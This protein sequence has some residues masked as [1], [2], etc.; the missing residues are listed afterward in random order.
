MNIAYVIFSIKKYKGIEKMKSVNIYLRLVAGLVFALSAPISNAMVIYDNGVQANEV[1]AGVLSTTTAN[2]DA[3]VADDF[4]LPT[5]KW[6]ITDLHWLGID[7]ENDPTS[8][9]DIYFYEDSSGQPTGGP[10]DPSG[11]AVEFRSVSVTGSDTGETLTLEN[12]T[13]FEYS[14]FIDPV[15]LLGDKTYWL[16]IQSTGD[17]SGWFFALKNDGG[18]AKFGGLGN[19]YW[20]DIG[21]VAPNNCGSTSCSAG[22]QLTGHVPE[23]TT[24][25]L[26]SLGLAGLGFTRRRMK[27]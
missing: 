4:F 27:A 19:D 20:T 18:N 16:A 12:L 2:P 15:E 1:V 5:G 24:L 10:G 21:V 6:V 9:F 13:I 23:P 14:V 7:I 3:Q 26:F 11:T 8:T 25:T 22:F 17:D